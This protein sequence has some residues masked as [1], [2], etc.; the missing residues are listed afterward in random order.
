MGTNAL[1]RLL[2]ITLL[3]LLLAASAHG[4]CAI[5]G[6]LSA[7]PSGDAGLPAWMYTLVVTWDTDVEFALSHLNLLMD[8]VGGTCDCADFAGALTLVDPAGSSD[9]E[10]GC[11]VDYNAFLECGGDPSIPG[12]D[13]ILLK[14]EPV[15]EGC[16]PGPTGTATFVFYSDLGPVPV[17]EDILS[18]VDKHAGEFCFGNLTGEFPGMACN[19]V[20][21]EG[22]S[23]GA[24]KGLYR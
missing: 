3:T 23:W 24:V 14:F 13:G 9:G 11:S 12:V 8:P 6:D 4:Q 7:A 19:P 1:A 22:T 20:P 15:E 21:G 2:T 5:T 17:D 16:E 18:L 10:G